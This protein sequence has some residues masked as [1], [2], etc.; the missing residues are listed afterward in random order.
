MNIQDKSQIESFTTNINNSQKVIIVPHNNPDGDALGSSLGL[1]N[2]L[3]NMGKDVTV[4]S[5]NEFPDFLNWMHGVEDVLI[6]DKNIKKAKQLINDSELVVFVDFNALSRI[7]L[8]GQV[9][10]NDTTPRIMIDHHPYPEENT[11]PIQISVPEASS[12]CELLFHVL[13]EAGLK[14]YITKEAA[15]CIYAGI[16]TDTGSL[17]YNSSRPET[18]LIVAELLRMGIDKEH[19]HH[20]IFHNNSFDR[21]RL[22]G[23]AL[24]EKMERIPD[25]NAA[26][27][28]LSQEELKRFNFK[29]GDTEGFVNQALWI[30]GVNLSAMFTEK[31][32]IVKISFRS[33]GGFP[34]NKFSETYFNGG[35]HFNAAGGESKLKL[36]ETVKRFKEVLI[37][38][39][40]ANGF[41]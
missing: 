32:D 37:E 26:F 16:M 36:D 41:E 7:K 15:E 12:T 22:L 29:P 2:T 10:E 20:M 3:K 13:S 27:I 38:F 1:C 5:P 35:G 19:I 31:K 8:M 9:F 6:Y 18:Y 40:D 17:N 39:C 25:Q 11:A 30:E 14:P 21:M 4:I 34:A 24:G 23:H 33:R 28:A